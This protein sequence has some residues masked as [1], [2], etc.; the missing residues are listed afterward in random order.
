M[1][2]ARVGQSEEEETQQHH[3]EYQRARRSW[4]WV[5]SRTKLS[6]LYHIYYITLIYNTIEDSAKANLPEHL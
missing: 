6:P 2:T 5:F 3:R 4:N 1:N